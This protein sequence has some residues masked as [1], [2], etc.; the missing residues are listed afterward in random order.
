MQQRGYQL[1]RKHWTVENDCFFA[2]PI[3]ENISFSC[4]YLKQFF[5]KTN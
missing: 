1:N 2:S 4:D 5:I 3:V